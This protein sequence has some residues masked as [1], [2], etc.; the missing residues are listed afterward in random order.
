MQMQP[1]ETKLQSLL[2]FFFFFFFLI[3]FYFAKFPAIDGSGFIIVIGYQLK[4]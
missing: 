1:L 3:N 2:G 4:F